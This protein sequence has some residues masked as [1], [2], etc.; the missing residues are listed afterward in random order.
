MAL[1]NSWIGYIDRTYEQIKANVLSRFQS[2]V[3]EITDHTESNPWVKGISIWAGL[4]EM[5]GYTIDSKGR[6]AYLATCK[7]FKSGV[8]IA[9]QYDYRVRGSLAASVD[10]RFY[11]DSAAGQNITI[12]AETE[13]STPDGILFL[14][15]EPA[16]LLAGE[17]DVTVP[18]KQWVKKASQLAGI[19]DG[20]S[21]QS[22]VLEDDVVDDNITVLVGANPYL[23][24]DT[25]AYYFST[26]EVFQNSLNEDGDMVITFGDGISGKIPPA[27]QNIVVSYYLTQGS[28]GNVASG[29]ITKINSSLNLPSGVIVK[30]TNLNRA[31]AGA[32]QENLTELKK[33]IPLSL[34]T[35]QRAVT[36][37]DYIDVAQLA[38]GVA[39]A[40]VS[41]EQGSKVQLYIS[42]EGGGVANQT[43]LDNTLNYMNQRRM[44]TTQVEVLP[45][46]EVVVNFI[47]EVTAGKN[48]LK[49]TVKSSVIAAMTDFLS[50]ENQ[51]ISG[52]VELADVFEVIENLEGVEFSR[53]I[54]MTP[55]P[56]ARP[57][58]HEVVLDWDVEV[59]VGSTTANKWSLK[60]LSET[61][62]ELLKNDVYVG[63]Y[64]VDQEVEL[65]DITFTV[66]DAAG[67]AI[68]QRWEFYSY[69]YYGSFKLQEKSI[70]VTYLENLDVRMFGGIS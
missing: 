15:T 9:K 45:A 4:T 40:G 6:E 12:P 16:V 34:R 14:T 51:D 64:T 7:K 25:F 69:G 54:K 41:F 59:N 52:Q 38:A 60:M 8:K 10:L 63:N 32:D 68:G 26:D 70:P 21:K 37:Q 57:I 27:G 58:D 17:T 30:V 11:I 20:S 55:V 66:N 19:S 29:T 67:Y 23:F 56:Y 1:K 48:Y 24:V 22:Y 61:N 2:L 3:P 36:E 42:P 5:L 49:S 33:N 31:S 35:L 18:A 28:A 65:T 47:I 43:L 53:V 50:V 62:F 13:V 44:I 46:G 39:K